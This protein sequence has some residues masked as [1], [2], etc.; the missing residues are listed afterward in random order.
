MA[1]H[2]D[3]ALSPRTRQPRPRPRRDRCSPPRC[4]RTSTEPCG[5][6]PLPGSDPHLSAP[7]PGRRTLRRDGAEAAVTPGC[8]QPRTENWDGV[9]GGPPGGS[10]GEGEGS[11]APGSA[12]QAPAGPPAAADGERSAGRRSSPPAEPRAARLHRPR[13]AAG[14]QRT[15]G[16]R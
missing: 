16:T 12:S 6:A 7:L 2:Q 1:S 8:L 11:G 9:E 3:T 4:S 15:P 10:G 14:T 5:H 13:S